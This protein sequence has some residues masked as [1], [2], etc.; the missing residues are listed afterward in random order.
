VIRAAAL[1]LAAAA[2]AA[3]AAPAATTS[4]NGYEVTR[5]QTVV[6]VPR[7]KLGRKTI[8]RESRVGNTEE[9]DGNSSSFTM[10]LGGFVNKCPVPEGT[11]ARFVVA[12]DFEYSL[13][14]DSVN[15]DVVP[16]E[17]KHYL[18][19]VTARIKAYVNDDLSISEAD[20]DGEYTADV[21]GVRTGPARI[22]RRFHI[23]AGGMP[24]M[25]ALKD[26]AVT[27]D[28]AAAALMWTA[29]QTIVLTQRDLRE[30]NA[31]AELQF[32]PPSGTRAV[33]AGETVEIRVKY[34]S[35]DAQ[36]PIPKGKWGAAVVQGGRVP[37]D[38]GQVRTDG[39]FV[40]RYTGR[41]SSEPKEGDGARIEALSAGGLASEHW[42]IR[43][44]GDYELHFESSIVSRN[45]MQS[46]RSQATGS[47][48]LTGSD[49]PWKLKPDGKNYR[50]YDGTGTVQIT[51]QPGP[52]RDP[53]E[54][55]IAGSSTSELRV[56]DTYIQITPP[57]VE[58]G[59]QTGGKANIVLAYSFSMGGGETETTTTM[60]NFQCV[61]RDV[62]PLPYWWMSYGTSRGPQEINFLRDWE[63]V[64]RDG[65]VARKVL[66]GTC[67]GLCNEERSVFT[68]RRAE[69]R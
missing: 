12:G 36:Q 37:E 19:R 10:T 44:G 26:V 57:Q 67:G 27:S 14:A 40:V 11:P 33:S 7:G 22:Q 28:V 24:D 58:N 17:R 62:A 20:F 31:C 3:A 16:T 54:A 55:L 53:C 51:T 68:L 69:A 23:G 38:S 32:D 65:I 43:V 1:V 45:P 25:N 59:T 39:T 4:E 64:G 47:A 61:P 60:V 42:K 52:E 2:L 49:K 30:P 8:D 48:K 5:S 66:T 15:T 9:T 21:E 63:Y 13:V 46:V 35:R 56:V 41:S 18:K 6:P 29:S 50:L 34:R